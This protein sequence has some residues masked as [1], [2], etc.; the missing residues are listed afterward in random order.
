MTFVVM[1]LT[2]RLGGSPRQLL[3]PFPSLELAM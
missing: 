2:N 1:D 3:L